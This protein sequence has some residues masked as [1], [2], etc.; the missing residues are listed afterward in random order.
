MG[1]A[2][3]R[4]R[5]LRVRVGSMPRLFVAIVLPED[6]KER[7]AGLCAGVPGAR[8]VGREQFHLSLRFIGE[9]DGGLFEDVAE[10]LTEISGPPLRLALRGVGHFESGRTPRVLWVGVDGDGGLVRLQA[11]VERCLQRLGLKPEGR[12][13]S[14]HITLARLRQASRAR[15][16]AF[17]AEQ[18]SF[19]TESFLVDSFHLFSSR[20]GAQGAVYRIEASYALDEV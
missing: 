19:A 2:P 1:A 5:R 16:G 9:V 8:W 14:P 15:V 6:L 17:L 12:R 13:F 4:G 18:A 20:L 3:A 7:L 11:K 10:A